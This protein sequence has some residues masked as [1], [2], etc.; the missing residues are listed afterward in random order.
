MSKIS[1]TAPQSKHV[2]TA[3][4]LADKNGPYRALAGV[5]LLL[6]KPEQ[7]RARLQLQ[8]LAIEK[9]L[10]SEIAELKKLLADKLSDKTRE[11]LR[12]LKNLKQ[13]EI[14]HF[15][16]I[17]GGALSIQLTNEQLSGLGV[18]PNLNSHAHK[19][20]SNIIRDWLPECNAENELTMSELAKQFPEVFAN[21][22]PK[23]LS[24]VLGCGAGRFAYDFAAK[25]ESNVL[26]FDI[27]PFMLAV[28][29]KVTASEKPIPFVFYPTAPKDPLNPG[30]E[31][32][33]QSLG[34]PRE[35]LFFALA[36]VYALPLSD[37]SVDTVFTPWLIDVLSE[38]FVFLLAE[39]SRVLRPGGK[40]L[41]FGSWNFSFKSPAQNWSLTELED[42]A[43]DYGF[44]TLGSSQFEVP[45]LN[46]PESNYRRMER[47]QTFLWERDSK[48][49][50]SLQHEATA[51][52]LEDPNIAIPAN[53]QMSAQMVAS[54]VKTQVLSLV[55]GKNSIA[56]I[57]NVISEQY[58]LSSEQA[59]AAVT[60]FFNRFLSDNKFRE[61]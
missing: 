9:S 3:N 52:W 14:N 30:R 28:A 61:F 23:K 45:Y 42:L 29:K 58:G 46:L 24:V 27:N 13:S 6:P 10:E 49:I 8:L 41:N 7:A 15:R 40:W 37:Q 43:K 31:V 39:I 53:Q 44:N 56:Q 34:G 19:Y 57:A 25:T 17:L 35:N 11:R 38:N 48:Q 26:A 33:L 51:S 4:E 60:L 50:E 12:N 32:L 55:D 21:Q 16:N 54:A 36:D 5:P 22:T 59:L 20:R 47:L 18:Q 2:I 1:F